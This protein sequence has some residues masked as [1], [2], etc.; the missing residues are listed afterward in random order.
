MLSSKDETV[1]SIESPKPNRI[2][3]DLER[4]L[5]TNYMVDDFQKTYFVVDSFDQLFEVCDQDF[6]PFYRRLAGK[7]GIDPER[8]LEKDDVISRGSF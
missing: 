4:V 5:S 1:Y 6:T 8:V 3:F 2:R 7:E